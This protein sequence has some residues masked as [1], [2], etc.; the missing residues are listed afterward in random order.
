MASSEPRKPYHHGDLRRALLVEATRQLAESDSVPL[1]FRQLA[2]RLGVTHA[3]VYRHFPDKQALID[4]LAEHGFRLLS[5][6]LET[7]LSEVPE[8]TG[9]QLLALSRSYLGFALEQPELMR[10]M[11]SGLSTDRKA[12]PSLKEAAGASFYTLKDL[13]DRAVSRGEQVADEAQNVTLF[14]W[15]ALHGLAELLVNRQLAGIVTD[16]A[17]IEALIETTVRY[18]LAGTLLSAPKSR[19]LKPLP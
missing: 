16:K 8:T 11:F 18:M 2:A 13:V 9:A 4:A 12:V 3:A 15:S 7:A 10:V 14:Y 17:Q 19:N 1:N 5:E 6:R